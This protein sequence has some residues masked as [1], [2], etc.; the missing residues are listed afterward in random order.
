MIIKNTLENFG[1]PWK[2]RGLALVLLHSVC[3]QACRRRE[4]FK[5]H[6]FVKQFGLGFG[7]LTQSG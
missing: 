3:I 7:S 1:I 4:A 5:N 2:C 6:N